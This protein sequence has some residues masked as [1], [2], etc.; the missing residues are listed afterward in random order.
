MKKFNQV[1]QIEIE[2]DMVAQKLLAEFKEDFKHRELLT[3][4]IVGTALNNGIVSYLYNSL[5]GFSAD[6]D[7]KVGD[8]VICNGTWYQY[9]D[10]ID[11]QLVKTGKRVEIG[12]C[13]IV[14][15]DLYSDSKVKVEFESYS[16]DGT[17]SKELQWVDHRKCSKIPV[18]TGFVPAPAPEEG[19]DD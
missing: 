2:V 15:I 5:N 14:E 18:E 6:I 9:Y 10:M 19:I 13:T 16:S 4:T 7:F 1:I 3:E 12:I 11:N 17:T 8:V